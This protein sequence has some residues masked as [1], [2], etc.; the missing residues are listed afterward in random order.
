MRTV[1]KPRIGLEASPKMMTKDSRLESVFAGLTERQRQAMQ[2]LSE[3]RTSKEIA[4]LAGI[5][6]SA[7]IQRIESVRSKAGGLLRKNLARE[8]RLYLQDRESAPHH[9]SAPD[10]RPM[11]PA[12]AGLADPEFSLNSLQFAAFE[13]GDPAPGG[14]PGKPCNEL[15]GNF[16]QLPSS[17]AG[18][19]PGGRNHAVEELVLADAI[20]FEIASPWASRS[21]PVVVPKV[22]DGTGAALNRLFAATAL[23]LGLLVTC[24]V[25]L[26][27]AG[28]IAELV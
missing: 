14:T 13:A 21:E 23:A 17:E 9:Q 27:V 18:S 12:A 25:L 10:A 20:P 26:A 24:L 15:T 11:S 19:H 1:A 5:S 8:Y 7:A 3:G 28:E 4:Y 22:L 6:E 16:F 2:L